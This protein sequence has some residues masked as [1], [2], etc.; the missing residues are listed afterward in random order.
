VDQV[1]QLVKQV[2]VGRTVLLV[3][4]NLEVLKGLC[5]T[6]T[7]LVRG[8]VVAQGDYKTVS[9]HPEVISAYLGDE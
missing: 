3:E 2:S 9:A 1:I 5:D 6:V 8:K 4:H 7:V